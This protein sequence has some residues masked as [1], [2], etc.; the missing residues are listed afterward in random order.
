[1]YQL[2]FSLALVLIVFSLPIYIQYTALKLEQSENG[3][4]T[5]WSLF[6]A[7]PSLRVILTIISFPVIG[8]TS[9]FEVIKTLFSSEPV[10]PS[11]LLTGLISICWLILLC[12]GYA[13][14]L[15]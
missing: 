9:I 3:E 4:S 6:F 14:Y 12:L 1:M 8:L 7:D 13:Q 2:Y 5:A 11:L 10:R 15:S